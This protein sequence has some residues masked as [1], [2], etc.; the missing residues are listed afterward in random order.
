LKENTDNKKDNRFYGLP[1]FWPSGLQASQLSSFTRALL[2]ERAGQKSNVVLS[3]LNVNWMVLSFANPE[4]RNAILNSDIVTLDGRPLLWL[5][6]LFGFPMKELVSGS[7]LMQELH[8][9]KTA[10]RHLTIFLFGGEEGAARQ[11]MENINRDPGGLRAVGALNPGFGTVFGTVEEMSSE[12]II[13][14]INK[15]RPDILLVALGAEKGNR[16]IEFNRHRLNAGIISHLGATINFLAGTVQRAPNLFRKYGMEWFWRVLQEPKLFSRYLFDGL[17]MLRMLTVRLRLLRQYLSRQ[18]HFSPE[19]ADATADQQENDREMTLSFGRN[20]HVTKDSPIRVLFSTCA[21]SKRD[22][23]LDFQKT[24]FVDGAFM[25]LLLILLKH[26]Q[27]SDC[28]LTFSNMHSRLARI[29][30]LFLLEEKPR[31]AES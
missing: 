2:R 29:L 26:Q 5:A 20:V 10:D 7:T 27:R 11:A 12:A 4:F 17:V 23:T 18:K 28:K 6:K 8:R 25:G 21:R 15:T 31:F 9:D 16:W 22:I 3:T 24:E 30:N 19:H 13:T 1:A 14:A